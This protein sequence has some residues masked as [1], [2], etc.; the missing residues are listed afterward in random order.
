MLTLADGVE[1]TG[2]NL[3]GAV[4]VKPRW[5]RCFRDSEKNTV[6]HRSRLPTNSSGLVSADPLT[7]WASV[8]DSA[9]T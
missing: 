2:L 6:L 7:K 1:M 8:L 3:E 4:V 5:S 9:G